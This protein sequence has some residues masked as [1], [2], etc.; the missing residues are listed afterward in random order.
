MKPPTPLDVMLTLASIESATAKEARRE[1]VQA[2]MSDER[3]ADLVRTVRTVCLQRDEA[4][5]QSN[6]MLTR[7]ADQEAELRSYCVEAWKITTQRW[8]DRLG[9][10]GAFAAGLA[11]AWLVGA[12]YVWWLS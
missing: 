9:L 2:T 4:R 3:L 7:L 10:S 6:E 5:R 1:Q 12:I 8:F 11:V